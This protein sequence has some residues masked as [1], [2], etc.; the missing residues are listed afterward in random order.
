MLEH[1]SSREFEEYCQLLMMALHRCKVDVTQQTRDGGRDLFVYHSTGLWIVECK[2]CPTGTVGRPVVQKLHSATLTSNSRRAVIVTTGKFSQDAENYAQNLTD[3]IIELID[4]A[5]LAHM[6]SVVFPYGALPTNLSVAI[7]TTPDAIFAQ[8]F[9]QSVFSSDRFRRGSSPKNP[10]RVSRITC[11]ET[12]YIAKYFAEGSVNSAVGQ[13]S[14]SWQGSIWICADGTEMGFGSPKSYGRQ[15]APLVP[16]A[17]ALATVP[18]ASD[19]PV[20]Q[21]HQATAKMK[22]FVAGNCSKSVWYTGRNNVKYSKTINPAASTIGIQSL[23]LCYIP[24]QAFVLEIGGTS[25]EGKLDERGSPPEFHVVCPELSTC[26]VCETATTPDNQILCSVCF[27][28][29][30]KWSQ[31]FPDSFECQKCKGIMCR[32]HTVTDGRGY[33]CTRCA[34]AGKPLGARWLH[35]CIFG[36]VGTGVALL[37]PFFALICFLFMEREAAT[38]ILS[39]VSIVAVMLGLFSWMPFLT[40][41][42]QKSL[43]SGQKSLTYPKI[44]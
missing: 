12:Y 32:H 18:G 25:Y 42:S 29:A 14:E 26:T 5:K 28:P 38:T 3:I 16:L 6:I 13:F 22:Q 9:A 20:V 24:F 1:L 7:K 11:Y 35:L 36:L 33:S 40:I 17:E 43:L 37:S 27:R 21:P 41:I 4:M 2:H 39:I 44:E 34:V 30:H 19:P 31:L 10:V 15:L 8:I 23:K